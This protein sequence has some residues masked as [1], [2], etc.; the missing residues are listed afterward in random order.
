VDGSTTREGRKEANV[1]TNEERQGPHTYGDR[2]RAE[3]AERPDTDTITL[4]LPRLD[5][6][7]RNFLF[8]M[9]PGRA[10]FRVLGDLPD[11]VLSHAR[12]ARREQLLALRG[13]VDALIQET[14][15]P[16][17]QQPRVREIEIE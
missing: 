5:P 10:L 13:L 14:D 16:R 9:I 15:R 6:E 17:R 4:R 3:R 2:P 1:E 12:N 11:D 7:L 8:E